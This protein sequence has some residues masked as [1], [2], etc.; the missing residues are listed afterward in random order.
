V[1]VPSGYSVR[2]PVV[3]DAT[4]AAVVM[5]AADEAAD[6]VAADDVVREW[7]EL[8][9]ENDVW[10]FEADGVVVACGF[11]LSRGTWIAS[12]GFVDPAHVGCGLGS[13]L[14]TL[15]ED[16]ARELMPGGKLTNG[17]VGSNRVAVA[18]LEGRGFRPVRH[19]FRMAVELREPPPEPSWPPGLEPRPFARTDAEAFH[20][21]SEEAFANEWGHD[22]EGF[23]HWRERRLD[24]PDASPDLWLGVWEGDELAATLICDAQ[25]YG[26]GWIASIG[27]R[28]A[29]RRRGIG[30]AL[31]HH[32]LG[33]FWRRG[34]RSV[35]L[36]VD[37]QN[38]TG[39]TRLYE[40]AGMHVVFEAIVYEKELV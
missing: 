31:L 4:A 14:L 7:R 3:E 1:N 15:I 26:L 5:T 30:L 6:D 13:A 17:I 24:A 23:E 34:V 37:A 29:W 8:D 28:A 35:G 39:A 9:L 20:A 12:E 32:A 22:P 21:A 27:A 25:R 2:H 36:G 19:F 38:P 11:L 40:R 33:E 16:R 18:L 10:L